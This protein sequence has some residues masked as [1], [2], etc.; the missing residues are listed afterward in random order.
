MADCILDCPQFVVL[1]Q[2]FESGQQ[3]APGL[4]QQQRF[5]RRLGGVAQGDAHKKAV[6]LRLR[7]GEGAARAHRVLRGDDKERLG[8]GACRP[9]DGDLPLLHGFEQRA[10]AFRRGAVDLV[11]EHQL[12]E[13]RP[14]VEDELPAVLVEYRG[15]ENVARQQVGRELDALEVQ[16][17]HFGQGM[18]Q[19]GLAHPG[20]VLHQQVTAGQQ[21][22]HG[23]PDL[24]LLA[25]Q[26][27]IDCSQAGVQS[28][29]HRN[30]LRSSSRCYW[31]A[32]ARQSNGNAR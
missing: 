18:T 29:A 19:G 20:H 2:R 31:S 16:A 17:Q 22:G 14:G 6:Q 25:E 12:G 1:Q 9:F 24:R 4:T 21:A 15:A 13:D 27:F 7:Q 26:Y 3:I 32:A 11:G 23:Q 28:G 30:L 5:F 10:L 8:Q